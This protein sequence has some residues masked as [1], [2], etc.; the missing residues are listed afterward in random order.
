MRKSPPRKATGQNQERPIGQNCHQPAQLVSVIWAA[1][2]RQ[3]TNT[4]VLA[5]TKGSA[6]ARKIE[7][8]RNRRESREKIKA[9]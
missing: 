6:D 1:P 4:R 2:G 3:F 8:P 9:A 5:R 7:L